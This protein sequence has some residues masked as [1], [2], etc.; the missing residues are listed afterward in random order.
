MLPIDLNFR[1]ELKA[2]LRENKKAAEFFQTIA[3]SS[4]R[5]ILEWINAAK[6]SETKTKRINETVELAAQKIRA[7]HYADLKRRKK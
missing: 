1:R 7:N 3:P 4:K 5:A 6:T 2:G